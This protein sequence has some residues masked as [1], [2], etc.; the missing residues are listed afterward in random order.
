MR[1]V[2][3]FTL[4]AALFLVCSSVASGQS[5]PQ[6][7]PPP[8]PISKSFLGNVDNGVYKNEFFGVKVDIPSEM[9]VLTKQEQGDARD[10]GTRMLSKD[11]DGD[12]EAW[13]R[14]VKAE[15]LLLSVSEVKPGTGPSASLNIGVIR[16][17]TGTTSKQVA[18]TAKEFLLR[19]P[20]IS[21][22]S[23]TMA[24]KL[25]ARDFSRLELKVKT[26]GPELDVRY[27]VTIVRGYSMTFVVTYLEKEQ[28]DRFE[29]VLATVKF[30]N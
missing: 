20:A 9:H 14:A 8:R 29:K 13:E 27:Y 23:N 1:L 26:G 21:I 11:V 24:L 2:V 15:V 10:G 3:T 6:P 17:S 16:Q 18:D 22:V 30:T 5:K 28:L 19:N 7:P 12:Q 4:Q 25:A